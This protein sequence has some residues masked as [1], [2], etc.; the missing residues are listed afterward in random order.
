L[1]RALRDHGFV[2]GRWCKQK[3]FSAITIHFLLSL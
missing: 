1:Q 2:V 3:F